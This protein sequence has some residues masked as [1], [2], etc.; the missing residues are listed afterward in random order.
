MLMTCRI[1]SGWA[2]GEWGPEPGNFVQRFVPWSVTSDIRTPDLIIYVLDELALKAE[3]KHDERFQHLKYL[4]EEDNEGSR[5]L[6]EAFQPRQGYDLDAFL[7]KFV[8]PV[9][10]IS[11]PDNKMVIGPKDWP[12]IVEQYR[13][14]VNVQEG[15]KSISTP[16]V[17]YLA[18]DQRKVN[19]ILFGE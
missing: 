3:N 19:R 13:V 12:N 18:S 6:E 10:I 9:T 16:T 1:F 5:L 17:G 11:P 4:I 8:K 15:A 2:K 7:S 14:W